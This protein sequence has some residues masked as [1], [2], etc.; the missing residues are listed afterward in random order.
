MKKIL[1]ALCLATLC[2][3]LI[4][5]PAS[6][7]VTDPKDVYALT[8]AF[9]TDGSAP[10]STEWGFYSI[11]PD[12]TAVAD[13]TAMGGYTAGSGYAQNGALLGNATATASSSADVAYGFTAPRDGVVSLSLTSLKKLV[14]G[15]AALSVYKDGVRIWPLS[16]G[17]YDVPFTADTSSLFDVETA[18]RAGEKIFFRI[19]AEG[20]TP[21]TLQVAPVVTYQKD[22]AYTQEKDLAVTRPN[23][24]DTDIADAGATL[25]PD[26]FASTGRQPS[27]TVN[28]VTGVRFSQLLS[29][30]E[31]EEG[32]TYRITDETEVTVNL[33]R[34]CDGYGCTVYAPNGM[35]FT[36]KDGATLENLTVITD[37][38]VILRDASRITLNTFEVVGINA[39]VKV[40]NCEELNISNCRFT[41]TGGDAL[42]HSVA[43]ARIRDSYFAGAR[44]IVDASKGGCL[45]ENCVVRGDRTAMVLGGADSAVWY[46]TFSGSL[47]AGGEGAQNLLVA[48]NVFENLGGVVYE[49]THNS[50]ILFN[51]LETVTVRNSTNAY[52]CN[53]ALFGKLEMNTVNYALAN[54]NK[55]PTANVV[56]TGVKNH[57]GDSITD[58]NARADAGVNEDLLPHINKDAFINM[59]RKDAVVTFDGNTRSLSDY[60]TEKAASNGYIIIAPGAYTC[61]SVIKL[62]NIN[63][64]YVYAYGVL[65]EGGWMGAFNVSG[66]AEVGF[67]GM[68][69]DGQINHN[70]HMIVVSV[71]TE[72]N[73]AI[74]IPGAGMLKDWNDPK[75]SLLNIEGGG[76]VSMAYREGSSYPYADIGFTYV[77]SSVTGYTSITGSASNIAMLRPGDVLTMRGS[78][79]NVA[80]LAGNKGN[81]IFEDVSVLSGAMRCFWDHNSDEGTTL[82]RVVVIPGAAKKID[83]ATYEQYLTYEERFGVSM[84][85]YVDEW[86]NYRGMTPTTVTA[87]STHQSNCRT[88]MKVTSCIFSGLSDDATNHQGFHGRLESYDPETGTIVYKKNTSSLGYTAVCYQFAVGDR[89]YVYT[90]T[91]RLVCDTPALSVTTSAGKN[92]GG[93]D[94]YT[95]K[96]DPAA[97]DATALEGYDLLTDGATAP[98]ILIDNRDRNGDGLVYDNVLAQNIRSRGFLIKS[99]GNVIKHCTFRNIGMAAVAIMFE[100]E[101]G[102][103]GVCDNTQVLNNYFENTGYYK[104]TAR[105]SPITVVGLGYNTG[106]KYLPY[107]NIQIIGNVIRNRFPEQAVYINS[108]RDVIIRD[109]DFGTRI[110]EDPDAVNPSIYIHYAKNVTIENNIYPEYA[111]ESWQR[112]N[113][114]GHVGVVGSDLGPT[115]TVEDDV[116]ATA[117]HSSLFIEHA[118]TSRME[119]G[120][121]KLTYHGAWTMGSANV[122]SIASFNTFKEIE[123]GWYTVQVGGTWGRYGGIGVSDGRFAAITGANVGYCYTAEYSG[124]IKVSMT[125]FSVPAASGVD[126]YD[127][128]FAIFVNDKMVWPTANGNYSSGNDWFGINQA[129]SKSE[130]QDALNGLDLEVEKGDKVYFM[131]KRREGW[132]GYVFI[133]SVYYITVKEN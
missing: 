81:V 122:N 4:A 85:I 22:A 45:Y 108:A 89:V 58:V 103:S 6:N 26:A 46:S 11:A 3:G 129:T 79:G 7:P 78:S 113:F 90:S 52:V 37:R 93:Y 16:D 98:K 120:T 114:S 53:N 23:L 94:R 19:S 124:S 74:A 50:V 128:Y 31:L 62:A 72:S 105:Y 121:E 71:N 116:Y 43:D 127:G 123:S 126:S 61:N 33:S 51:S 97:F 91:G 56:L 34:D 32:A 96:V 131:A 67:Y 29:R 69:V 119:N 68:T 27:A 76:N 48:L 64:F 80:T 111:T 100:I 59:E 13:Y 42:S 24:A 36:A 10:K 28:E 99:G 84:G 38:G 104:N 118:P 77:Y 107:T 133:P 60:I 73:T 70:G 2:L 92:E 66:C 125:N 15:T 49:T 115:G 117:A 130:L 35:V 112:F 39:A 132:S 101:W 47:E 75:Y 25:A 30:E 83:E 44:G 21:V 102:E 5:C 18:I 14:T 63:N 1:I 95:V 54:G 12:K 9:P 20:K 86:G 57:N 109:N 87:D 65:Y 110:D 17:S 41:A 106:D 40:E 8:D 55:M 82:N 88:G